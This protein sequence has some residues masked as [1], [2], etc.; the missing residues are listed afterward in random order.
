M[1][2][3]SRF[4]VIALIAMVVGVSGCGGR[5]QPEQSPEP[6]EEKAEK[7]GDQKEEEDPI[8]K[9]TTQMRSELAGLKQALETGDANKIQD[10][11][12]AVDASWEAFEQKVER[13]DPEM[14]ARV[15]TSH[16]LILAAIP[17]MPKI[18]R[19]LI[20]SEID[21]LDR[22]LEELKQ[23]KGERQAPEK[24]DRQTGS[25]AMRQGLAELRQAVGQGDTAHMQQKVKLV[26]QAW[27]QFKAEVKEH[28]REAYMT[29]EDS[30][31]ALLA[32]V[33]A[34]PVDR[35]ALNQLIDQLDAQITQLIE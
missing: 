9:G 13:K 6:T 7:G 24:V 27:T 23:T 20:M 14:Y 4:F 18:D 22:K 35:A 8:V 3:I 34:R 12:R 5:Q 1:T 16:H 17:L 32:K 21:R 25:A 10:Q 29:I 30:F 15:E 19:T 2:S 33:E 28:Q 26:D 11:A 31:H